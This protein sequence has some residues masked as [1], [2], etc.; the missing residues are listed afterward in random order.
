M[1]ANISTKFKQL[2]TIQEIIFQHQSKAFKN[3][4]KEVCNTFF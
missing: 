3:I 1:F 4:A 2:F